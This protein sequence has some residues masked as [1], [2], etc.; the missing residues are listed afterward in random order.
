MKILFIHHST[1]GN[2]IRQG[3]LRYEIG[4]LNNLIELWDHS[5]NLYPI[6]PKILALFTHHKGLSDNKGRITGKDYNIV[7]S[8]NSPKEYEDIFSR[9][10]ND[11]TLQAI[12]SY[13]VIAFKNCFPT[14]HIE[15][16]QTLNKDREYY[17]SIRNSLK[18]YPTKSFVILTPPPERREV[19]SKDNALRAKKL[20]EWLNSGEFLNSTKNI[21]VFN[22]FGYLSDD[23]GYLKPEYCPIIPFDSH[24]NHRANKLIAPIF[25]EF[26]VKNCSI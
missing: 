16:E 23:N 1:G 21:K 18:N 4:K 10:P 5:Y 2:L 24:P 11:P 6:F 7:L 8:N 22:L 26:I 14:S 3:N 13:D 12:L 19:N 25:A 15:S 9:N 20:S 17:L